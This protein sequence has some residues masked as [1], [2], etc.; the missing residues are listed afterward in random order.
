MMKEKEKENVM[1]LEERMESLEESIKTLLNL[2]QQQMETI[3]I[4]LNH[5]EKDLNSLLFKQL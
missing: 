2:N 1:T 5:V 4:E 3:L